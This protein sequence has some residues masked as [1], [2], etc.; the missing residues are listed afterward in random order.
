MVIN[1][2]IDALYFLLFSGLKARLYTNLGQML[3]FF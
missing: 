1:T 3:K 2:E